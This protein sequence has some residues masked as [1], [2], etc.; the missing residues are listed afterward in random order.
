MASG[1]QC[2]A[3]NTGLLGV[4][5]AQNSLD[6]PEMGQVRRQQLSREQRFSGLDDEL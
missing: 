2:R 3:Q 6:E 5:A 1:R 4:D